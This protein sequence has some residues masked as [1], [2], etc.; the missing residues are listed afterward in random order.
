MVGLT[1]CPPPKKKKAKKER[2]K[3][4][5]ILHENVGVGTKS[6]PKPSQNKQYIY[7]PLPPKKHKNKQTFQPAM[8]Y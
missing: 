5:I 2:K 7:T 6:I 1:F 8:H 3:F 4:R